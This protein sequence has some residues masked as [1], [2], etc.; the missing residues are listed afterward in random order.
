MYSE[1]AD[2]FYVWLRL[3]LKGRY[4]WFLPEH[5]RRDEELVQNEKEGKGIEYFSGTLASIWREA[6]RVLKDDGVL[7][8]TFHHNNPEAWVAMTESLMEAGFVVTAAPFVRSEGKSGFHSSKGNIRYDAIL[9]CRKG[10]AV[11]PSAE[12]WN[13]MLPSVVERARTWLER[14]VAL[15][16][17]LNPGDVLTALMGEA[18]VTLL[19]PGI[20]AGEPVDLANA[21]SM[22]SEEVPALEWAVV[23][24]SPRQLRMFAE[25]EADY[26]TR[27]LE[28]EG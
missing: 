13:E 17:P 4:P 9:V 10:N 11:L 20:R 7:A 23:S 8:F 14:T 12:A 16:L 25:S 21:L 2:F 5:S 18:L 1:L 27:N 3:A 6:H 19:S 26:E 28:D 24:E 15:G 22:L